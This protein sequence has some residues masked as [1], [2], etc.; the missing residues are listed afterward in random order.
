MYVYMY[1]C[2]VS[3]MHCSMQ[4]LSTCIAVYMYMYICI[5]GYVLAC[6]VA[7]TEVYE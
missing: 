6:I 2:A 5:G 4:E 7:L 1:M 3:Y